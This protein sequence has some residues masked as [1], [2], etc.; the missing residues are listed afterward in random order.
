MTSPL[1][2]VGQTLQGKVALPPTINM[3]GSHQAEAANNHCSVVL[4]MLMLQIKYVQS[5]QILVQLNLDCAG[6]SVIDDS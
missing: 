6:V 3:H 2:V 5:D 4:F 1:N